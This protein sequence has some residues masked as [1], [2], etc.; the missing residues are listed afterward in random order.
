MNSLKLSIKSIREFTLIG[1]D[2]DSK[3]E[4]VVYRVQ[5]DKKHFYEV[6]LYDIS[7]KNKKVIAKKLFNYKKDLLIYLA[8]NIK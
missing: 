8:K 4:I 6:H 1:I 5:Q 3:T 2:F 7:K